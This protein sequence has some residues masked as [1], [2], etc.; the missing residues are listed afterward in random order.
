MADLHGKPITVKGS[1]DNFNLTEDE[2]TKII[3]LANDYLHTDNASFSD[4]LKTIYYANTNGMPSS[5][6]T[7]VFIRFSK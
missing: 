3:N 5:I 6:P 2:K 1:P 7:S 4:D